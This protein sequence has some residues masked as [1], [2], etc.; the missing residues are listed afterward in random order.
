MAPVVANDPLGLTGR[1]RG[2]EDVER[3][4]GEH[5][6]TL[7]R[8]RQRH[9][10]VPIPV[11]T[12]LH[13]R[14]QHLALIDDTSRLAG[15]HLEGGVEE[16]LVLDNAIDLDPTRGGDDD[17]CFAVVDPDCEFTG[18]EPA[19]HNRVNCAEPGAGQHGDDRLRDHRHVDDY[20]VAATDPVA[21]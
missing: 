15:G 17:L 14:R 13:I 4:G 10:L 19:K 12:R 5:R 3:I 6:D 8:C 18:C 1:A 21:V 16:R 20:A 11:A 2:V 7:V 9:F